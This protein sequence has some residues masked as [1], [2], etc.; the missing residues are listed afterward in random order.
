MA[1]FFKKYAPALVG[2]AAGG[3]TSGMPN[4]SKYSAALS[5]GAG[6]LTGAATKQKIGSSAL[7]GFLGGGAGSML[8]QGAKGAMNGGSGNV[9]D[10]FSSGSGQGWRGYMGSIPGMGG[11]GTSNPTGALAKFTT[12]KGSNGTLPNTGASKSAVAGFNTAQP[13]SM[14]AGMQAATGADNATFTPVSSAPGFMVNGQGANLMPSTAGSIA[15][16][17]AG[18]SGMPVSK[19]ANNPVAGATN[20]T[21]PSGGNV[22]QK[23]MPGLLTSMAGGMFA[24]DVAAPD[25]SAQ[26]NALKQAA[27]DGANPEA[28][29]LGMG[30]LRTVLNAQ[31]GA[32]A[33]GGLANTKLISDRQRTEAL[34]QNAERFK[35]AMPGA[36]YTQSSDYQRSVQEINNLYDQ[37]YQAQ[38]AQL[39]YQYDQ[40]LRQEKITAMQTALGLDNTQMSY[41]QSIA[42]LELEQIIAQ[43]GLDYE[44]AAQLKE[45]FSTTGAA[46][47][48]SSLGLTKLPGQA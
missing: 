25:F 37:N 9:F 47:M 10:A 21:Q 39:Q 11:F 26:T 4:A 46:M 29:A 43:T 1:N 44:S 7:Q 38:A 15:T 33:E 20:M 3:L 17:G 23:A 27:T 22:F 28:R 6:A 16:S 34:K 2:A 30:Q 5:T 13:Y 40:A 41:L 35:M 19:I 36:D 31:T 45:L 48:E 24:G 12:A 42:S 14:K 32:S 8:T 18:A